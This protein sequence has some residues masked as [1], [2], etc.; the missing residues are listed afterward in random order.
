MHDTSR[1]PTALGLASLALLAGS[2]TCAVGVSLARDPAQELA[3]ASLGIEIFVAVLAFAGAALSRQPA[4]QRLGLV[5]GR[6]SWTGVL[7]LSV[8][9]LGLSQALDTLIGLLDLRAQS[10]LGEFEARLDGA[11]GRSLIL[12]LLAIG[13]APGLAEE[14]LCR[15]LVQR[16]L[17][18]RWG[19]GI[20][21][22]LAAMF[23]GALHVGPIHAGFAVGLGLYLGMAAYLDGSIRAAV[24]CHVANNAA[25]VGIAA[26]PGSPDELTP[27]LLPIGLL[28]AVG[29]LEGVRRRAGLP[30]ELAPADHDGAPE[31]YSGEPDRTNQGDGPGGAWPRSEG[32]RSA[33]DDESPGSA[34][35]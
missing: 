22:V 29:C 35:G 6:L 13:L 10:A 25:A 14:L 27:L 21:I 2:G 4:R 12:A 20:G 26:W 7:V 18:A 30:P 23:F 1:W 11:S 9:T 8:G 16:G 32:P 3:Y 15:G 31:R 24:V 5:P 19:P 28:A 34:A 17:Q 33:H